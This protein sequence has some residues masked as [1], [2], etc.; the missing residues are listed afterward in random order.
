MR[1]KKFNWQGITEN[2]DGTFTT[3]GKREKRRVLKAMHEQ[4]VAVRSRKNADGSYTV[5]PVGAVRVKAEP[6]TQS[7]PMSARPRE[8]G[9]RPNT[10]EKGFPV[11]PRGGRSA[12]RGGRP[13]PT[14]RIG[15]G[16]SGGPRASGPSAIDTLGKKAGEY[17][18]G[19][20]ER[21]E[22]E[23]KKEVE[24]QKNAEETNE[25]MRKERLEQ[26]NLEQKGEA[27]RQ[28]EKDRLRRESMG[29]QPGDLKESLHQ[30]DV[31]AEQRR[32]DDEVKRQ[33][34]Q[35]QQRHESRMSQG[36]YTGSTKSPQIPKQKV[37]EATLQ[38]A[39]EQVVKGED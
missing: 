9:Y 34:E 7:T 12:Q 3:L 32:T 15:G 24:F 6:R 16:Y 13:F 29:Q 38:H 4:G 22:A 27:R 19:R 2:S 17:L 31:K 8:L 37:D 35:R 1:K 30:A 26:E 11:Y 21:Q 10:R 20:K 28:M 25:K 18:R 36:G 23:R 5:T 33:Q 14:S 39:R